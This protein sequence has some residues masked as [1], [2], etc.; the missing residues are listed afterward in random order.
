MTGTG[1]R[2]AALSSAGVLLPVA[3]SVAVNQV[4]NS[5]V[6]SRPWIVVTVVLAFAGWYVT[7]LI[8]RVSTSAAGDLTQVKGR[9]AGLVVDFWN[10]EIAKRSLGDPPIPVSWHL[11]QRTKLMDHPHLIT[12]GELSFTG[13]SDD[14]AELATRFRRLPRRRLVITGG[15]G[16]GKTTLAVQLL[17]QLIDTREPAEPVPMLVPVADWD[18][19]LHPRLHDWIAERLRNDYLAPKMPEQSRD[20]AEILASG[21]HIL[22]ILDGLDE[23]PELARA[24]V[25]TQLGRTLAPRDQVIIT[26]RTGEYSDALVNARRAVRA[27]A[28]IAPK[29]LI[30]TVVGDY[31]ATC[32]PPHPPQPWSTLLR[33]LRTGATPALAA[34][35]STALGLWLIRTVYVDQDRD[36]TPLFTVYRDDVPALRAHL[37]DNLI[38]ALLI[39]QRLSGTTRRK[40]PR[41]WDAERIR[42]WLVR[43]A[44]Y[45]AER[46]TPDF[47][48]WQMNQ[49]RQGGLRVPP[50]WVVSLVV[51]LVYAL[52]VAAAAALAGSPIL[53]LVAGFGF[54]FGKSIDTPEPPE[55]RRLQVWR[56][57]T[58]A[59]R[60][61]SGRIAPVFLTMS[62]P[63][64]VG[65]TAIQGIGAGIFSAV[66]STLTIWVGLA[67]LEKSPPKDSGQAPEDRLPQFTN[68][69]TPLSAWKINRSL[70]GLQ[71]MGALVFGAV[72]AISSDWVLSYFPGPRDIWSDIGLGL[73]VGCSAGLTQ[74]SQHVWLT[75]RITFVFLAVSGDLPV[76]TVR[77]FDEMHQLGL[78]RA[79]GPFYQLRHA[80][81][82]D[83]FT[84]VADR[85]QP[86]SGG[87][88]L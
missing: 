56:R 59:L 37:M 46:G 8:T 49:P 45:A 21:G 29:A 32:L 52:P 31:L 13:R 34:V 14:I 18:T 36:P 11:T 63:L 47:A 6:W 65:V 54:A 27:A 62:L 64:A 78:L 42:R 17:V 41:T 48:W 19:E 83:H 85:D 66:T 71:L 5:G 72:L 76:R 67:L 60:E 28:V 68:A 70:V 7:R 80:E 82:H 75:S 3:L 77:F 39:A 26:S 53:G 16:T 84:A 38:E 79:V 44:T 69:L 73:I 12:E 35:S 23:L 87:G 20:A 43:L 88:A 58:T 25:I 33:A 15:A 9:L 4:L 10:T 24:K 51:V 81:L 74:R 86:P 1:L 30:P 40:I 22:A 57:V 61:N 50:Q 55:L 2:S